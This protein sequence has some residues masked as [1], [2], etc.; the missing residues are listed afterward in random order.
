MQAKPA[1]DAKGLTLTHSYN[2]RSSN[3]LAVQMAQAQPDP[4][5][6]TTKN[7][8]VKQKSN[9]FGQKNATVK[10]ASH[11]FTRSQTSLMATMQAGRDK[12]DS[13]L[14]PKPKIDSQMVI[15]GNDSERFKYGPPEFRKDAKDS[16][17]QLVKSSSQ[18]S[19]DSTKSNQAASAYANY[20]G[21]QTT[22]AR[23]PAS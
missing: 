14:K 21:M 18:I 8:Q 9:L 12:R 2:T 15:I 4:A 7:A 17:R 6:R 20:L 23:E 13:V 22:H 5:I 16:D 19:L 11:V 1:R 3:N 10:Q